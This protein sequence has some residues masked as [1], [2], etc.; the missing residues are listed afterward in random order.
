MYFLLQFN[1]WLSVAMFCLTLWAIVSPR[2]RDGIVIKMG[3]IF[4][5]VG[6]LG[7]ASTLVE[8]VT[9]QLIVSSW[10]LVNIGLVVAMSGWLFHG[11]FQPGPRRPRADILRSVIQGV[12]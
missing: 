4:M 5:L 1:A 8:V 3:L 9:P 7:C 2:I 10:I 12:L 11:L 6:Y